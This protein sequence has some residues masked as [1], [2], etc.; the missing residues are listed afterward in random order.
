MGVHSVLAWVIIGLIAG[1][2]AGRVVR[3][4]GLGCIGDVVVGLAGA[5][6]GGALL[7]AFAP[8]FVTTLPNLVADILVAF[9]GAAILLSILRLLTPRGGRGVRRR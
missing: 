9:I 4:S 2:L 6:I 3:G 7:H 1:A 8:S 5:I